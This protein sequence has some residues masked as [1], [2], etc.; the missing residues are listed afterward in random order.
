MNANKMIFVRFEVTMKKKKKRA[1]SEILLLYEYTTKY[2]KISDTNNIFPTL[3]S[4]F[5]WNES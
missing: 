3:T 1:R 2:N 5:A 4:F